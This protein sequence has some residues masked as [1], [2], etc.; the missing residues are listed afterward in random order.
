MLRTPTKPLL[1]RIKA[2]TLVLFGSEDRV[3]PA[4]SGRDIERGIANAQLRLLPG[5]GHLL[6]VELRDEVNESV[7]CFLREHE[8]PAVVT[9]EAQS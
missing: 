3:V 9:A 5:C 4:A 1:G 6:N 8:Q 2:P 7:M